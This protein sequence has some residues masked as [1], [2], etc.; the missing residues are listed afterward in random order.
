MISPQKT[1]TVALTGA[2]GLP[3]GL[4]L[5]KTLIQ[6]GHRVYIVT[7]TAAHVVAKQEMNLD[8][9]SDPQTAERWWQTY[10]NAAD[11]QLRVFGKQAW[12]APIASG[13]NPADAMVICPCSMGSLAAVAHGMSDNLLERAADV[14]IK[15][16]RPLII[17]PRESP[18]SVIHLRNMLSL[19]EQGVVILPP[20]PGFYTHP[21]T[22]DDLVHFVVARILDQL[23]IEHSMEKRWGE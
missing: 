10:T 1:I 23:S 6:L 15:E 21:K 5:I 19:T 4:A 20:S 22:I 7:S 12:F 2:S 14:M 3:Y 13:S 17:V 16:K 9:P 18:F 8:L 11:G